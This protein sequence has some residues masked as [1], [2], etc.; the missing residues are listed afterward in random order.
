MNFCAED[1][2]ALDAYK[3]EEDAEERE[4]MRAVVYALNHSELSSP[5]PE[6]AVYAIANDSL[7]PLQLI[8]EKLGFFRSVSKPGQKRKSERLFEKIR[9]LMGEARNAMINKTFDWKE[10]SRSGGSSAG[11]GSGAGGTT[12][13]EQDDHASSSSLH[14]F[15]RNPFAVRAK[16]DTGGR[17]AKHY[18]DIVKSG[19]GAAAGWPWNVCFFRDG[20]AKYEGDPT[21]LD[22]MESLGLRRN[23]YLVK[24]IS[25]ESLGS[26]ATGE[27]FRP[28]L[29]RKKMRV[30][31]AG[32][33]LN[34]S[35]FAQKKLEVAQKMFFPP[36]ECTYGMLA[37]NPNGVHLSELET[38]HVAEMMD[39]AG[40]NNSTGEEK[41]FAWFLGSSADLV[42]SKDYFS[43]EVGGKNEDE[44]EPRATGGNRWGNFS[45]PEQRLWHAGYGGPSARKIF[46]KDKE[47]REHDDPRLS[48]RVA[49]FGTI[50]AQKESADDPPHNPAAMVVVP[51]PCSLLD[52]GQ[53]SLT[54]LSG[55]SKRLVH[56]LTVYHAASLVEF[57][58]LVRSSN[59][60][61]PSEDLP[62]EVEKT[63]PVERLQTLVTECPKTMELLTKNSTSHC[64]EFLEA[65]VTQHDQQQGS[66][67]CSAAPPTDGGIIANFYDTCVFE[68]FS[69]AIGVTRMWQRKAV[70]VLAVCD[71]I[72]HGRWERL[73]AGWEWIWWRERRRVV[74]RSTTSTVGSSTGSSTGGGGMQEQPMIGGAWEQMLMRGELRSVYEELRSVYEEAF[75]VRG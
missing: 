2:L 4:R 45:A 53:V 16:L 43:G 6:A 69:E 41:K 34:T 24:L 60:A 39:A 5:P 9:L 22:A 48:R 26:R 23:R 75:R 11:S 66:G 51:Q 54:L 50:F 17:F 35:A 46:G 27:P 14:P 21:R 58:R 68:R 38:W 15:F 3:N 28:A 37:V 72:P 64:A 29:D 12:G 18:N 59:G 31:V 13:K 33:L 67:S 40:G 47:F 36:V 49:R 32:G 71:G 73:F 20:A 44:D 10:K 62:G 42:D 70:R 1:V 30:A 63:S 61:V 65:C 19:W 74:G 55:R 56:Y 57:M 7:T 8:V 25:Q 52:L